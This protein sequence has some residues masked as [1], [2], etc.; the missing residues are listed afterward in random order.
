MEYTKKLLDSI[1]IDGRRL[2]MVNLSSAMGKQFAEEATRLHEEALALG[3][4]PLKDHR[5]REQVSLSEGR[6]E[7]R[8]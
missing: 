5:S 4:N 1:G 7:S 8:S 6:E 3:P 2:K